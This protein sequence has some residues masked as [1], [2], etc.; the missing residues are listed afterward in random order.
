MNN[1]VSLNDQNNNNNKVTIVMKQYNYIFPKN[2]LNDW[3]EEIII[4]KIDDILI[5]SFLG[6]QYYTPIN[7][8][9]NIPN[10]SK[11]YTTKNSKNIK[12]NNN[13]TIS[14]N[15]NNKLKANPKNLNKFK[16]LMFQRIFEN[17]IFITGNEKNINL[18]SEN[19]QNIFINSTINKNNNNELLNN[20]NNN[21]KFDVLNLDNQIKNFY[22]ENH[23]NNFNNNMILNKN[24]LLENNKKLFDNE[25]IKTDRQNNLNIFYENKYNLNNNNNNKKIKFLNE[26][27]ISENQKDNNLF[28]ENKNIKNKLFSNDS[29]KFDN[30]K[31]NNI[32]YDN[33][34]NNNNIKLKSE[35]NNLFFENKNNKYFSNLSPRF[36]TNLFIL[37]NNNN[38]KFIFDNNKLL[39]YNFDF[40]LNNNNS[41][42]NNNLPSKN[43]NLSLIE[44]KLKD[45]NI[46]SNSIKNN[47]I[48]YEILKEKWNNYNKIELNNFEILSNSNPNIFSNNFLKWKY[49]I[50]QENLK[51]FEILTYIK[52][53]LY[54]IDTY[55]YNINPSEEDIKYHHDKIIDNY[56]K[57]N[58][59]KYDYSNES[60]NLIS[61]PLST[62]DNSKKII[63]T[64]KAAGKKVPNTSSGDLI[65]NESLYGNVESN[66]D[67]DSFKDI[68][69]NYDYEEFEIP[70]KKD[71]N[72]NKIIDDNFKIMDNKN[73]DDN[74]NN[75]VI[76]NNSED[77]F[78]N[79]N[80][81]LK[82]KNNLK[83][84][85]KNNSYVIQNVDNYEFLMEEKFI[86]EPKNEIIFI[87]ENPINEYFKK[88][89]N[90]NKSIEK[91][92]SQKLNSI[93][94]NNKNSNIS[95]NNNHILIEWSPKIESKKAS[96]I[97]SFINSSISKK[98]SQKNVLNAKKKRN[99]ND[100]QNLLRKSAHSPKK[101][102]YL[103]DFITDKENF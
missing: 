97:E 55:I 37:S 39:K 56:I 61:N 86:E 12:N 33:N 47:I 50:K 66:N 101:N 25:I 62:L 36:E 30:Q 63:T 99:D 98:N 75:N 11:N 87:I 58:L 70:E 34:L 49:S 80:D 8:K 73:E 77:V 57:H 67:K 79:N 10:K 14:N 13:N 43:W 51:G 46:I 21:K 26:S 1:S 89:S 90:I 65:Y 60:F 32:F 78:I 29:L 38:N 2:N 40:V 71:E 88:N 94:N 9:E 44:D 27:L 3:M 52:R 76:N 15:N 7:K 84:D 93:S 54:Q 102:E 48:N 85:N 18:I 72:Y 53:A 4:E 83:K 92:N 95:N 42:N 91:N 16:I 41:N 5:K 28:Y 81:N 69:N 19:S 96:V 24:L 103:R 82:L 22:I 17:G 31:N 6:Y 100:I 68:I 64:L 23:N 74:Y 45:L 20:N 35:E 59:Y